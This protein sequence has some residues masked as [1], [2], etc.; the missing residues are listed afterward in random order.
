VTAAS[1]AQ[2][3]SAFPGYFAD[4]RATTLRLVDDATI[5]DRIRDGY[6]TIEALYPDAVSP[7]VVF[8]IGRFSTGGTIRQERILIGTEFYAL[9]DDTPID[10]LPTFQ[11]VNVKPLDSIPLIV[12]H[13]H[14]H[15]LQSRAGGIFGGAGR[16]LLEQ[17]LMEGSADFIGELAVGSHVNQHIHAYGLLHE[18]ELWDEF[19]QAMNG[20]NV[21]EWLYNQGTATGDRPGDLGYFIGYRIAQAYYQQAADK[22]AAVR[23]IIEVKNAAAFLSASGYDP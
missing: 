18:G 12:A 15:V 1:L 20:T 23:E 11:R 21:S 3:V 7:P 17:S 9:D 4:I 6:E 10:E 8:L 19:T 13:E 2:M 22:S 5:R 14:A 16:T